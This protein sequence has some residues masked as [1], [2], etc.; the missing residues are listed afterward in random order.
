MAGSDHRVRRSLMV[1]DLPG[2]K[3]KA[4]G[5]TMRLYE[6]FGDAHAP[7]LIYRIR[8]ATCQ[9]FIWGFLHYSSG[10]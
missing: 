8:F 7:P 9:A 3:Q 10:A 1:V 5:R 4:A 2:A 6:S